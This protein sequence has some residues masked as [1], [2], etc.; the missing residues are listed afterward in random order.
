MQ[1]NSNTTPIQ[2]VI[3]MLLEATDSAQLM[4]HL[5]WNKCDADSVI[6]AGPIIEIDTLEPEGRTLDLVIGYF[7]KKDIDILEY[8]VHIRMYKDE[9]DNFHNHMQIHIISYDN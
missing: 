3:A 4:E 7:G 2:N 1:Q 8:T 6:L 5:S 9:D